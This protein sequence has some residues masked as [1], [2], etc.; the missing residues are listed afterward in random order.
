MGAE[1]SVSGNVSFDAIGKPSMLK[2]HGEGKQLRGLLKREGT[3]LS[4]E[5]TAKLDDLD[6]GMKL[7]N[8]HM[9]TKYLEVSKFP[10]SKFKLEPI[11]FSASEGDFKAVPFKGLMT[12]H[13]VE[14]SV[15][16]TAD[17]RVS[18]V[19]QSIDAN[20]SVKL[21]DFGIQIP[22][23]AGVT[24]AEDVKVKVAMKP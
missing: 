1:T 24:V 10:D 14:K 13:G 23:F 9:R 19:I 12:L 3:R 11:T 2:I 15:S 20:F 4:G 18:K 7:R 8:E 6:T 17:I 21:S 5:A 22:T 16:G